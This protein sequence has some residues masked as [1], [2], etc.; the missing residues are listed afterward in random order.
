MH[1]YTTAANINT[2]IR[3]EKIL[4]TMVP[5]QPSKEVLSTDPAVGAPIN[6]SVSVAYDKMFP[7]TTETLTMQG[8]G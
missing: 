4:T 1:P 7:E 2:L 6:F 8:Y 5:Q 3:P